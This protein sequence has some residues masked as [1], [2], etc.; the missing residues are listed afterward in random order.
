MK[1]DAIKT[2]G[3]VLIAA[4]ALIAFLSLANLF[5][6][7]AGA[8]QVE[9]PEAEDLI[10]EY[11]SVNRSLDVHTQFTVKNKGIYAV[12]HLDIESTL[13]THTGYTLVEFNRYD[14]RVEPGEE[15][16][17]PVQVELDLSTLVDR[18]L[19]GFLVEDGAFELDVRIRADYTLGLTKFRSDEHI[20]YPW[21]S[22]VNYL[23]DLLAEGNLSAA[24][25]EALG[26]AGPVVREWISAA[27][28]DAA[29][30]EGEWR[31]TD[32]GG[33]AN[34]TYRLWVNET[35]GDGAFDVVLRGD[36]V[37]IVWTVSGSVPL[38]MVDGVVY[39]ERE[40]VADGA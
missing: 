14:L 19:L 20:E 16:T 3:T 39:L 25:E 35:S 30:A 5:L 9:V 17:F 27:V 21:T 10:Y 8:I 34:M 4:N 40:V 6:V 13:T 18:E 1:R 29:M 2:F 24:V 38:V 37:G 32:L 28:L 23:R 11:D 36:V 12:R 33:W 26:W 31:S 22:P 7:A 15:R